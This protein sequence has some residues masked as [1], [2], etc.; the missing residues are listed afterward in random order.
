[1]REVEVLILHISALVGNSYLN[2]VEVQTHCDLNRAFASYLQE[3]GESEYVGGGVEE[4]GPGGV[5][6]HPVEV[7]LEQKL[8]FAP[9]NHML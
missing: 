2:L 9:E 7:R 6:G 3:E 5:G 4:S 8:H 1:M